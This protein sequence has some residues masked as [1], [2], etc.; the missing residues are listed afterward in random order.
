MA[1]EDGDL[2]HLMAAEGYLELGLPLEANEELERID[3][4]VR[5]VPEVLEVRL[6]IYR[7]MT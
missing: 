6:G 5:H 7:K 2:R 4:D 1:L 3:P